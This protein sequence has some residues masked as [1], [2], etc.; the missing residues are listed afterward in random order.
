[1]MLDPSHKHLARSNPGVLRLAAALL[2]VLSLVWAAPSHAGSNTQIFVLH[3]YSQEYPWTKRQHEGFL[4]TLGAAVPDTI[5]VSV[6]YLDS[7]RVPYTAAYADFVAGY[8]TQKYVGFEPKF[9]YVT[10][11]NALLFALTHLTRIFPKAPIFFSGI[12]DYDLKQQIDP[13]HVTGVF[14]NKEI[15]PNLELMRHLAPGVRD[16]LVVGDE[17]ETFQAIRREIIAELAHQPD[18]HAQFLSSGRIEPLVASLQ[19]RSEQFVFLTTL[20]AMTDAAG[21]TLTLPETIAAIAQAGRFI[22]I[23]MED[24]YLYPGVLG[25]YVT[26][27]YKQGAAAA[28]LS[29][30]YLAGTA[31]AAI[32]PI[33]SSPN[34]Y[35]IDG[36]ELQKL[37]LTLPSGIAERATILNPLPTF[38]ERNLKLIVQSLYAF[39]LLFLA[40]LVAFIYALLRKNRQIARTSRDLAAQTEQLRTVIEGFPVVLWAIDC[41]GIFTL[42]RGAGLKALRLAPDEVVG[43]S[44]FEIY[45]DN[46]GI[47]ENTRRALAGESHVSVNWAGA[48]AFETHYAPL[49]DGRG[50]V[51]GATGVSTDVTERKQAEERLHLAASVFTHAREGIMITARDGTI[52]DVNETFSHITGYSRDE[53]LGRNARLLSSVRQGKDFYAA[54]L[55]DLI[56]KGHWSG[57]RWNRR[58]N[59]EL[60]AEM[61]TISAV[62]DAQGNTRQY[63]ALFSDITAA[64]EHEKQLEHIAHYDALTSLPNRALLADRLH[65]AM[66][67]AHRRTQPLAVAYLD[68]D[69]FKAI[70]DC[71]GHEIG[72]QLLVTMATRMKHVLREGDTLSRLGGDEFAVVLLDL[73]DVKASVPMLARLLASAAQSVHV[74]DL[75]LKVSASLGVTF[76]P[77]AEDVD[78]DQLLRQADQAMYQA[79]LAGKNRYHVFDAE[80]DRSV[81]GHHE[82]RERIRHALAEREFVLHYQPK[83]NMRTGTVTGAEA[84]IRWQHP[85]K[86]LLRPAFFLP[87]IEDHPLAVEIGEWVIDTAL[88]QMALWQTS[89]LDIPV[90]VN[91]G[92][93][94]LQGAG[95]PERLREILAAHRNVRPGDLELEILETIAL[96]DVIG[97]SQVMEACRE[98]GVTFALDDFGTGYSSLTYLR[99]LPVRLLKIDQSFVRDMLEDP[100]DLA[101]LEGVIGLATAFRRE[102]IAEGVETVEHG[103]MLLQLGCE[104]AQGYGIAH[105]MPA[106]ELSSWAAAWRPDPAWINCRPVS[107][108]YLRLLFASVEH[109][110][111]IA[112]IEAFLKGERGVPPLLNNHQ[113]YFGKWLDAESLAHR[114]AQPAFQTIERLH[115]QVHALAA[116]LCELH[117]RCQNPEALARLGELHGLRDTLLEQTKALTQ[118]NRQ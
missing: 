17:S 85:E 102:V 87:V 9:I 55:R 43:T 114:G 92:A 52:I 104:L 86:G 116:E 90:S 71:H 39:A 3:S 21:R 7:K 31:V 24:V 99:R 82:S 80:Q 118:E 50:S 105:P 26:S 46:P 42:S 73:P 76:Y 74:G 68:L 8:L 88:T 5:S 25:G 66:A 78:A 44:L 35:I 19:G 81:R 64:K 95:F 38:Y 62:R 84:L 89:G 22:I 15:A 57:E 91:V 103:E 96:E 107:R 11:D 67:Q 60:Y 13:R 111:W 12:N 75:V 59:G 29:A 97:V 69:G 47:I 63:V 30:R 18:I 1:M 100:D 27:G 4:R 106:R 20:G 61:L 33:E 48:L 49:R 54:M 37:G 83:V 70:N 16:I 28:E 108:D 77:Q 117:A 45:R 101:I 2:L 23:S 94:Q 112:A 34:E 98:I 36:A 113:C 58:K 40:S 79:K 109:R 14:E 32:R 6:E 56:E 53:A 51:I 10:D 93:R 65:Q 72:D 115:R 110:A 41:E